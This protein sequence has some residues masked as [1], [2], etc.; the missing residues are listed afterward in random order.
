MPSAAGS[1]K[2]NLKRSQE[3]STKQME[4]EKLSDEDLIEL[5]EKIIKEIEER[6]TTYHQLAE[7]RDL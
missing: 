6:I 3:K 5:L 4:I 7:T 1:P 2:R